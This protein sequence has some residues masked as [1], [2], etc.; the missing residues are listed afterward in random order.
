MVMI[1]KFHYKSIGWIHQLMIRSSGRLGDY[2]IGSLG[3]AKVGN[4]LSSAQDGPCCME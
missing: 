3:S 2:C 4:Y 1:M